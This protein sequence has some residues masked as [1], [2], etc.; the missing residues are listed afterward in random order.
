MTARRAFRQGGHAD[1]WADVIGR[2]IADLD[3]AL[4][5]GWTTRSS[6]WW[7]LVNNW[8]LPRI[9]FADDYAKVQQQDDRQLFFE[10]DA[11]VAGF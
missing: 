9:G 2:R 8:P 4:G 7:L 1:Q 10:P 6:W 5:R 11:P 3:A